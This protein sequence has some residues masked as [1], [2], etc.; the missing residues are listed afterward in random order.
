M[1]KV[2]IILLMPLVFSCSINSV[3]NANPTPS[4]TKPIASGDLPKSTAIPNSIQKVIVKSISAFP[5]Y[6]V[7]KEGEIKNIYSQ[8][9]MSNNNFA[10]ARY[11]R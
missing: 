4:S 7:L 1:K 3:P 8:L 10:R 11:I 9:K 5:N 2:N 6:V